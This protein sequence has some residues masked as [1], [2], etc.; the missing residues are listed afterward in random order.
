MDVVILVKEYWAILVGIAGLI[1]MWANINSKV[2]EI[3]KRIT[4][5]EAETKAQSIAIGEFRVFF[6]EIKTQLEFIRA[7]LSK[8]KR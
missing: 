1:T 6:G 5:L 4:E 7:E 3:D 2:K 8:K